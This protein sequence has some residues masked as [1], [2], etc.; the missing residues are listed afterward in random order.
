RDARADGTHS[1]A[2]GSEA[3]VTASSNE[4]V[5]L[6]NKASAQHNYG[7]AL[8]SGSTTQNLKAVA[9]VTINGTAYSVDSTSAMG[10]VSL[11]NASQTRQLINM[12]PGAVSNTSTDGVNGAQLFVAYDAIQKLGDREL[13]ATQSVAD[14]LGEG[15][16]VKDGKVVLP[17]FSL[18]SLGTGVAQPTS[19]V[20]AIKALDQAHKGTQEALNDVDQLANA[21][22][23]QVRLAM[24]E[25]YLRWSEDQQAYTASEGARPESRIANVA[26]G[27]AATDAVNKGQLNAVESMANNANSLAASALS[28]ANAAMATADDARKTASAAQEG[29]DAALQT[30]AGARATADSA[31]STAKDAS[32]S[33]ETAQKAAE[34]AQGSATAAMGVASTAQATA[35]AA[36]GTASS[37]L[38]SA[39]G[40]QQL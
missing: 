37:A 31:Q 24:A 28:G 3:S 35:D 10:V 1:V 21:T 5:A 14:A 26:A 40:A 36:Q 8:G 29:A 25:K 2:V 32:S 38:G 17:A 6:G 4:G 30:A 16:A 15:T 20:G 19:V 33:A 7:V 18:T 12:A 23:G 27:V 11:G 9:P 39:S 13:A 34:A 22:A